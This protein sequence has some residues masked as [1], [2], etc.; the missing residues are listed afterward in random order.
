MLYCSLL[1][2][3]ILTMLDAIAALD[4]LEE[5]SGVRSDIPGID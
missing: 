3:D 1:L 2:R 4:F 5:V